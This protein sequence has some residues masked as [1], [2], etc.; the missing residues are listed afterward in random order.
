MLRF[1]RGRHRSHL[2]LQERLEE[3]SCPEPNTGCILWM[4]SGVG[5]YGNITVKGRVRRVH[6]V[7]YEMENGPIPDGLLVCHKCDVPACI[8]PAHLFLGTVQ[9]NHADMVGKGRH[10]QGPRP[11]AWGEKSS[12]CRLTEDQ[13]RRI[14]LSPLSQASMAREFGVGRSTITAIRQRKTWKHIYIP[15]DQMP[16]RTY[17]N[18]RVA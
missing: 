16:V 8:N 12:S 6:R 9:D 14:I 11:D 3:L 17:N 4:G 7:V 13:V 10:R 2:S 1:G 18:R 5:G 15:P